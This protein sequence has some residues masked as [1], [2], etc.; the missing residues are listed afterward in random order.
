[1]ERSKNIGIAILLFFIFVA[2]FQ[3]SGQD[4][5][6]FFREGYAVGNI[7]NWEPEIRKI[8]ARHT[9]NYEKL[10]EGLLA[11]YGFMGYLIGSKQTSRARKF[12]DET[13]SLL[14]SY[15]KQH[16]NDARLMAVSA[17]MVGFRIGLSP[18]RAPFLGPRNVE[19]W[20]TALKANPNEPLA[21]LEKG[22]S[23][24]YRPAAFG[25]NKT[26]AELAFRR[27]L[28][29]LDRDTCNWVYSFV[30]VRLYEA[31]KANGKKSDAENLRK[32]LQQQPGHFRW[33]DDL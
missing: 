30:Q 33:I 16:P 6:C 21:H 29:L 10:M 27:A 24:F 25:G 8:E 22:N 32:E 2:G 13:E 9:G 14:N 28:Q 3:A 19:A 20:E 18:L 4:S 23:L 17:A 15:R 26:E 1:M 12:L 11:R 5:G 31:C 7:E